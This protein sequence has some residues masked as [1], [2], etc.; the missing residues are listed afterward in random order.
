MP[1]TNTR[2]VYLPFLALTLTF[3]LL[4]IPGG[5][6]R[7]ICPGQENRLEGEPRFFTCYEEHLKEEVR[8]QLVMLPWYS[9]FDKSRV[10]H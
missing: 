9:V 6:A 3:G 7:T 8:H 2:A 4:A 5:A 10:P 1:K